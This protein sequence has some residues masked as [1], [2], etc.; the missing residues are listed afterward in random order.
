M[1]EQGLIRNCTHT[2]KDTLQIQGRGIECLY[3]YLKIVEIHQLEKK[4]ERI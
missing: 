3:Y 2:L 1:G 4:K